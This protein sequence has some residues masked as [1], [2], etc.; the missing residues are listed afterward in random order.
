MRSDVVKKGLERAPHRMLFNACGL[1]KE[2][3]ERPFIGVANSFNEIVPGHVNLDK[4]TEAVKT[5]IRTAGGT[6]IEFGV[7][8]ICDG[9]A[10]GHEGMKYSLASR[11][12]IADS[13][14]SM[15]MAH[16]FDAL[17]MVPNCDK[18]IP[19][20]LM[21]A[22]RLNIPA[23]LVSGGPMLAGRYRGE[24]I[25][26]TKVMEGVGAVASGKMTVEE[27]SKIEEV[28]CPGCGSCAGMFTANSMN[29]LTEALGMG[30]PGNGTIPAVE[31]ARIRL[32][33]NAGA[34]IMNLLDKGIK[35]RDIMTSGAF[36][37]ALG[38]DMALGCST[39]TVLHVLAIAHEAGV[40]LDLDRFNEL[41]G[42]TP[43]LCNLSP[44]E[45]GHHLQDLDQAGG[46]Q[47]VMNE[48]LKHGM[49][50]HPDSVTVTGKTVRE[51]V[52]GR[53]IERPDVIRSVDDPYHSQGGLAVLRGNIAQDG[54]VVKQS[55]V[56]EEVLKFSGPAVV[57]DSEDEATAAILGGKIAKGS[58]IVVRYEGPRGGPGMREM[59]YPTASVAGMGMV[60]DVALITDGRFS[61]AS[62]GCSIGHVSPEAAEGGNIALI[63]DGDTIDVDIPGKTLNV[64]LSDAELQA[65][66]ESWKPREPKVKGGYL[67]RYARNVT[68]AGTG[69]V[70]K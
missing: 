19:G 67:V 7:I 9:I 59:L 27:L 38:V 58:V 12:L 1:T 69:A 30:L 29:C 43:H 28:A 35:P 14:E 52:S 41:S 4:I 17:V 32:A 21:A 11:E 46:V 42:R 25:S 20:M 22:A 45:N 55:A 5:G 65:R 54:A 2:E 49:L 16:A 50:A 26:F 61:G 24:E 66:R 18:I 56:A 63:R 31:A 44:A 36:E 39:N 47:A 68:S 10:M 40:Q 37:N 23:I 60:K 3:Q 8:G 13:I 6:P 62:R 34:A 33:K 51:N 64:R 48:L 70:V 53:E 57:F 15:A